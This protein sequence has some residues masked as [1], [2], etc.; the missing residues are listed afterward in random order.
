MKYLIILVSSL[1]L[2][3]IL[4][5]ASLRLAFC[6]DWTAAW[7]CML[8]QRWLIVIAWPIRCY[9]AVVFL[10]VLC[11]RFLSF[12]VGRCAQI[13]N[14]AKL[15][16]IEMNMI[17]NAADV[18]NRLRIAMTGAANGLRRRRAWLQVRVH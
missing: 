2:T 8:A 1:V 6:S 5:A 4:W 14:F 13:L 11:F 16:L 17:A 9:R 18:P 15:N 3:G 7:W 12:T 10:P